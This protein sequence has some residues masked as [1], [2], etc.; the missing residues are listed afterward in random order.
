DSEYIEQISLQLSELHGLN[1]EVIAYEPG[2]PQ[3][4]KENDDSLVISP[5]IENQVL[6]SP[7]LG[8]Y[9]RVQVDLNEVLI[10]NLG[11][12]WTPVYII[13]EGYRIFTIDLPRIFCPLVEK[14]N[15]SNVTATSKAISSMGRY[16]SAA[17][18]VDRQS[19]S[20]SWVVYQQNE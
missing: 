13:E 20:Y 3:G 7:R 12:E 15:Y 14:L 11:D 9:E 17:P 4:I 10:T 16:C 6:L 2:L 1:V 18:L 8:I 5:A 19:F